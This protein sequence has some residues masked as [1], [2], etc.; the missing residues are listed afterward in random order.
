MSSSAVAPDLP[1]EAEELLWAA[2]FAEA[3]FLEP[4]Q[5]PEND[6]EPLVIGGDGSPIGRHVAAGLQLEDLLLEWERA[7]EQAARWE[8]V[9]TRILAEALDLALR[10]GTAGSDAAMSVRSIA[11]ELGCAAGVTDRTIQQRMA[12]AADLRDRFAPTFAALREGRLSRRH[13]QVVLDEGIRLSEAAVRAEYEKLVLGRAG[14]LTTGRLRALADAVAEQLDPES[15]RD[16]HV[17]ARER[18]GVWVRAGHDGMAELN[19]TAPAVLVHGIHDRL[20]QQA[21]SVKD[22]AAASAR[23]ETERVVAARAAAFGAVGDADSISSAPVDERTFDQIRADVLCDLALTGHSTI[24]GIGRDGI[25]VHDAFRPIVQITI[26]ASEL[27]ESSVA[28]SSFAESS[29]AGRSNGGSRGLVSLNGSTSIDPDT[30]CRLAAIATVWDRLFTDPCTGNVLATDRR[31]P[32]QAQRRFLQARDEHCRFPGCR[33][34]VWRCDVDHTVDHQHGGPTDVCNLAHL[35]RRHH[36]LKHETS[37][38]VEQLDGGVLVWTSPLGRTY[39]D[40]P[41]PGLRFIPASASP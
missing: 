22:A 40:E 33:Q 6:A 14:G 24:A 18:R 17:R 41:A 16:R 34:P 9:Q 3:E 27:V 32:N 13:A 23:A 10:D 31:L 8:G 20:T 7:T 19:L 38:Q 25:A 15:I 39:T 1:P 37:W 35:C 36:S 12:D 30:A 29:S 28:G 26:P 11:A 5:V 21:R 2:R 4:A